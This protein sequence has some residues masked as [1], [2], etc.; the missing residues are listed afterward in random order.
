MR[1]IF[2]ILHPTVAIIALPVFG[3]L[4]FGRSPLPYLEFSPRRALV[5]PASFSV[6][7]FIVSLLALGLAVS[8]VLSRIHTIRF[9]VRVEAKHSSLVWLMATGTILAISWV[10][11]WTRYPWFANFQH[12]TFFLLWISYILF[13]NAILYYRSGNCP[14]THHTTKYLLLFPISAA[15]WW[16]FEYLNCFARNWTYLNVDHLSTLDFFL[17]ATVSFSTVLPATWTT[18][19]II[20]SSVS[21][22]L[23]G[24]MLANAVNHRAI[25]SKALLWAAILSLMAIPFLPE[26]LFPIVWIAPLL[27]YDRYFRS[28]GAATI[29]SDWSSGHFTR[30]AQWAGAGLFCGFLWELWNYQSMAHWTYHIPY[31]EAFHIF[32]MPVLGYF[33]YLPFGLLCGEIIDY[34]V[35]DQWRRNA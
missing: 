32:Q 23:G 10:L 25:T 2:Q 15:F 28:L 21:D 33:G 7:V 26:M 14:L 5:T 13:A 9:K 34:F 19:Q 18:Q 20:A 35:S 30:T 29:L 17:F 6:L 27:L 4:L 8:W 16:F 3:L 31:L 1:A 11:A 24:T 12:H 22:V